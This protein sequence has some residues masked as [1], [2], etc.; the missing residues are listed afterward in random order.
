MALRITQASDV[1]QVERLSVVIY[2]PPG[3]GKTSLAFTASRPLLLDFDNGAHRAY[4]RGDCVRVS[5]WKD[6]AGI[7]ATDLEAFDTVIVDTAGRALDTLAAEIMRGNPK[8]GRGGALTQQGWGELKGRFSAFLKLL[9]S[10]GTDVVLIA[11]MDEQRNGDDVMERLDVQGGSK[12]EIYKTAD[13]MGRLVM[14]GRDRRLNFSPSDAAFGKDPGQLGSLDVP[15][16]T[17]P[18]FRTFLGD[19]IAQT[20]DKLNA[21]TEAQQEAVAEQDWFMEALPKVTTAKEINALLDRAKGAG[22]ACK[23]LVVDRAKALGLEFD[24]SL[25]GYV[26]LNE[27]EAPEV[28]YGAPETADD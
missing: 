8:L 2:G 15:D 28:D 23:V 10:F 1:V 27:P 7:D 3:V 18:E 20:K 22:K 11:H 25:G 4:S 16:C 19:V 24:K 21:L 9:N 26:D 17:R 13:A 5:S 14:V 6:V 12:G